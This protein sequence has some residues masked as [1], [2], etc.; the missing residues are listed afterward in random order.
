MSVYI[1]GEPTWAAAD[2]MPCV[3]D[4]YVVECADGLAVRS[5]SIYSAAYVYG[6]YE[7]RVDVAAWA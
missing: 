5:C 2:L 1:V 3:G 7:S 6:S 4:V